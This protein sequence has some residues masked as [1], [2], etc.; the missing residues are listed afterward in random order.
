MS[1]QRLFLVQTL[2]EAA[3]PVIGYFEWEWDLSFILLF[4]LLDYLLAFGIFVAKGRKR[5][6]YSL[7]AEE[8][9]LFIRRTLMGF[10]LM[11]A[12]CAGIGLGVV[13]LQPELDWTERIVAFLAYKDLGIAQGYVLV[14]LIVLNGVMLYRQQF[15]MPARYR[16]LDMQ[17]ITRPFVRQGLVLLGSA[18]VLLGSAALISFPQEAVIFPAIAGIS[19]Y[20]WLTRA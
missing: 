13:F 12:A 20:R 10:L 11:I 5:L 7:N 16:Q 15:L 19:I 14:P 18:G 8:K 9:K 4:Y 1:R 6:D 17:T 2:I 3:I